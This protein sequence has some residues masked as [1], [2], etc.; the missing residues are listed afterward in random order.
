[1]WRSMFVRE[2]IFKTCYPFCNRQIERVGRSKLI[3]T[4]LTEPDVQP[5]MNLTHLM[6]SSTFSL[7]LTPTE[8]VFVGA[9]DG[10]IYITIPPTVLTLFLVSWTLASISFWSWIF[11][12][13]SCQYKVRVKCVTFKLNIYSSHKLFKVTYFFKVI[14]F[15][16]GTLTFLHANPP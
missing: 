6:K 1:M 10:A 15:H 5:F 13:C 7:G 8:Y 11:C 3:Q 2:A 14:C 12:L 9:L 4:N 16:M